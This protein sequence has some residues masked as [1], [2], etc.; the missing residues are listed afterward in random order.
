M[1]LYNPGLTAG[2]TV[3][4]TLAVTGVTS[5]NAGTS[6]AGSA[7]VLTPSFAATVASQLADLTRDY[8]VYLE[9]GTAGTSFIVQIGPANT[10]T[11]TI[12]ASS[13]ATTGESVSIR[14]PAGWWLKWSAV[15]ATLAN[16]TAIGC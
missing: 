14:L 9:I 12:V 2:G 13:T 10:T 6:T 7:P 8:M 1:P 4:G 3:T 15:T 11:T 16:Q 5:H